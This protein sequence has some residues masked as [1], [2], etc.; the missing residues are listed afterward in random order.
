MI[1]DGYGAFVGLLEDIGKVSF[2]LSHAY[3]GV[4]KDSVHGAVSVSK[5]MPYLT[6]NIASI[7]GITKSN[8]K[9]LALGKPIPLSGKA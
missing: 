1:Q 8:R 9:G 4:G 3:C 2:Q 7:C 5:L 6:S